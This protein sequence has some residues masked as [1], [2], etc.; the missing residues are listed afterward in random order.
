MAKGDYDTV[1]VVVSSSEIDTDSCDEVDACQRSAQYAEARSP[2]RSW[3]GVGS[4][5]HGHCHKMHAFILELY[6]KVL[7][8]GSPINSHNAPTAKINTNAA[9]IDAVFASDPTLEPTN[10]KHFRSR[11]FTPHLLV[12]QLSG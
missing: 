6:A 4:P 10:E 12:N 8:I 2:L 3:S 9:Q 1:I 7:L 5:L 11:A